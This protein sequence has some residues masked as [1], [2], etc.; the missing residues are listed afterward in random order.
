MISNFNK[1]VSRW[2][3]NEYRIDPRIGS[4]YMLRI[5]FSRIIMLINGKLSAIKH[6][7]L[8]FLSTKTVIKSR[9]LIKVGKSVTIDRGCYIDALSTTGINFGN[10]VSVGLDTT[11]IGTGNI[12]QVGIGMTVGNSVGL[13]FHC[14]YG[15]A[16][17]ITIGDD[18]IIGNFVSFHAENHN[19]ENL[20][21][22]IRLQGVSHKGINVG[23]NCW[24][25]AKATILDGV[26][27]GNGCV[28]AAGS[29]VTA[30]NYEP[31]SIYGGIPARLLKKR[32]TNG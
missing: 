29:V 15:C 26:S 12:Q 11:I 30:G 9:S 27:L 31:D 1:I 21:I 18:T 6:E 22:P 7:G 23:K 25:G 28:I 32:G 5:T 16:G 10:N 8:F 24:I 13:G 17:G 19:F 4:S 3:G 14:F 20:E 2:K